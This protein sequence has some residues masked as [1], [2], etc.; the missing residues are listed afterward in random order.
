[1]RRNK[2][3][4]KTANVRKG[5]KK[6][7]FH[8][9]YGTKADIVSVKGLGDCNFFETSFGPSNV[10]VAGAVADLS[11]IPQGITRENRVFDFTRLKKI[12]IH[13]NIST[14]NS[15]VFSSAR[16]AYFLWRP[17]T[18]PNFASI[19]QNGSSTVYPFYQFDN[20]QEYFRFY[21]KVHAMAG[22]A[23]NPTPSGNVSRNFTIH[24]HRG[25]LPMKFIA[26][27]TAGTN[28]IYAVYIGDSALSPFPLIT[29]NARLIYKSN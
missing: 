22:T 15:D 9:T 18:V 5:R 17:N 19:F 14:E 3:R 4:R 26:G 20:A 12:E 25:G 23:T 10:P 24:F 1:M 16:I 6:S 28:H 27:T 11:E 29:V 13:Y 7:W 8:I 2:P 21:D